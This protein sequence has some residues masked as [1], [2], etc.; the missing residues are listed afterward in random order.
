MPSSRRKQLALAALTAGF[1]LLL[2][3]FSIARAPIPEALQVSVFEPTNGPL[4]STMALVN[5]TNNTRQARNFRFAAEVATPT[6]WADVNGWVERQHRLT[7]RLPA[8]AA[9]QVALPAPEGAAKWRLRC[10]SWRDVS[11][12]EWAWYLLVRRTGLSRFGLREEPSGNYCW[13]AQVTQ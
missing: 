12:F 7:Q 6:G 11:K 1:L 2:L 4:G 8:H 5:V 10:A 13:T 3:V 9:C